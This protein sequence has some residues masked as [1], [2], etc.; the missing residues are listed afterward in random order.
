MNHITL[1]VLTL[2]LLLGAIG[3]EQSKTNNTASFTPTDGQP[4][5]I[6]LGHKVYAMGLSFVDAID[7]NVSSGDVINVIAKSDNKAD[8]HV[9]ATGVHVYHTSTG[10]GE[11][12]LVVSV[13]VTDEILQTIDGAVSGGGVRLE[14]E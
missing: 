9:L 6:P 7:G 12:E 1:H 3:C 2:F 8:E 5:S 13:L 14:R 11:H 4:P 10:S